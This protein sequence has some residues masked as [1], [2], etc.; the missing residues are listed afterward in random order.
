MRPNSEIVALIV[1][2]DPETRLVVDAG[3]DRERVETVWR[4]LLNVGGRSRE[5]GSTR[6]VN[7]DVAAA[8]FAA[9]FAAALEGKP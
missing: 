5:I 9:R 6:A 4:L 7:A 8:V 3:T 1:L 2:E